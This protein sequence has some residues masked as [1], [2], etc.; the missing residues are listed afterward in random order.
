MSYLEQARKQGHLL[1][2]AINDD[3]SV[4][5]L[6]GEY[7]PVNALTD[8]M[9]VLAGLESVDFVTWFE[10]DTPLRIIL[11]LKPKV[12]VKG[13]DYDPKRIVGATEVKSW[14]GVVKTLQFVEGQSSSAML[15]RA[16]R[17]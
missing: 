9:S 11:K 10:E 13:G 17:K 2:V 16:Q 3:A 12:L 7:R 15:K 6:K 4:R 5:R 8:R 1:I 14:G